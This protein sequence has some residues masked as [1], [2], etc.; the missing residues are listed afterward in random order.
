MSE[1]V[2]PHIRSYINA[3]KLCLNGNR[4]GINARGIVFGNEPMFV[5]EMVSSPCPAVSISA[6]SVTP[7]VVPQSNRIMHFLML[8]GGSLRRDARILEPCR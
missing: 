6:Q 3:C 2:S 5:F 8:A 4:T 1:V 7:V